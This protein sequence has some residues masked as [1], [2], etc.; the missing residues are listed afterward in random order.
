MLVFSEL[1]FKYGDS[2]APKR[3]HKD[4]AEIVK[5]IATFDGFVQ[6][7]KTYTYS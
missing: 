6:E 5:Y 4:L 7:V 3:S 2:R 1:R